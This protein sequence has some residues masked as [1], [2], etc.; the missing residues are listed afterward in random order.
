ME[1][2]QGTVFSHVH[3][4][5]L[6]QKW[7]PVPGWFTWDVAIPGMPKPAPTHMELAAIP[8]IRRGQGFRMEFLVSI[9]PYVLKRHRLAREVLDVPSL[10][11]FRARLSGTLNNLVQ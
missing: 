2:P 8:G 4:Q 9:V 7:C 11:M 1:Q 10:E 6:P 3:S 5:M